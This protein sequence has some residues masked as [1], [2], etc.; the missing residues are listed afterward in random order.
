MFCVIHPLA[1]ETKAG[2]RARSVGINRVDAAGEVIK[3]VSRCPLGSI[4]DRADRIANFPRIS[5][6]TPLGPGSLTPARCGRLL[7]M[8][9]VV[10]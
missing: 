9:D 1:N 3:R 6:F 4:C 8:Y 7:V 10:D 2:R 5:A